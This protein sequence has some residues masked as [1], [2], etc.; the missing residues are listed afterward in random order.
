MHRRPPVVLLDDG[1]SPVD[2]TPR[3][4]SFS[5]GDLLDVARDAGELLD[6]AFAGDAQARA[7]LENTARHAQD[8]SSPYRGRSMLCSVVTAELLR[9]RRERPAPAPV[10]EA[11]G[12]VVADKA[13]EKPAPAPAVGG[14]PACPREALDQAD[15]QYHPPG[16]PCELCADKQAA[17]ADARRPA[18]VAPAAHQN[19]AA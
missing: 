7:M 4:F 5:V 9:Q 13:A 18:H 11:R 10:V 19:G 2:G 14:A 15:P 16:F 3:T 1:Y 17:R 12:E 8:P 6:R